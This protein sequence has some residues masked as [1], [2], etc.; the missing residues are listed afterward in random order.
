MGK[1]KAAFR[2]AAPGDS[3]RREQDPGTFS[4]FAAAP[5]PFFGSSLFETGLCI[6]RR[7]SSVGYLAVFGLT[8]TL[9][10]FTLLACTASL[11]RL[12]THWTW[13]LFTLFSGT[14]FVGRWLYPDTSRR[15]ATCSLTSAPGTEVVEGVRA[16]LCQVQRPS[17]ASGRAAALEP[18]ELGYHPGVMCDRTGQ[19]P[20]VGNRY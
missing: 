13:M 11:P 7:Q 9:S 14:V 15:R 17:N 4:T 6:V 18:Q 10:V 2:A 5:D 12:L 3:R 16:W 19:S 8:V 20:I 1:R